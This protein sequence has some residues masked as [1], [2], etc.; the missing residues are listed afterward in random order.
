MGHCQLFPHEVFNLKSDQH[1]ISPSV[2]SM[3]YETEWS[4]VQILMRSGTFLA[5]VQE[6]KQK[7]MGFGDWY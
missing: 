7:M 4:Q 5:V 1:E 2:M 6:I 3:L